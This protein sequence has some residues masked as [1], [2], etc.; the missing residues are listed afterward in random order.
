MVTE[1]VNRNEEEN[2]DFYEQAVEEQP[3]NQPEEDAREDQ[4]LEG[5]H[6]DNAEHEQLQ[7]FVDT[8]DGDVTPAITQ[9][10]VP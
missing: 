5:M 9:Q 10:L 7:R 8:V 4:E 2:G 6:R 1:R 3:L